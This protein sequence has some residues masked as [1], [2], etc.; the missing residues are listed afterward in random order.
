MQARA[1]FVFNGF[2][3]GLVDHAG[4]LVNDRLGRAFAISVGEINPG[5]VANALADQRAQRQAG[6][7]SG[8]I[9]RAKNLFE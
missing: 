1:E 8:F 9:S 7:F 5:P 4:E 2:R 3:P 6:D